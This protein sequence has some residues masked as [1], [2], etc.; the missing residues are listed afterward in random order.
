VLFNVHCLYPT[1]CFREYP[2]NPLQRTSAITDILP[3]RHSLF[4]YNEGIIFPSTPLPSK[5]FLFFSSFQLTFSLCVYLRNDMLRTAQAAQISTAHTYQAYYWLFH[6]LTTYNLYFYG[7]KM[8]IW[9]S[10]C[11]PF[12][13]CKK[14]LYKQEFVAHC[15][16]AHLSVLYT[17]S[18]RSCWFLSS[19]HFL[20]TKAGQKGDR[21]KN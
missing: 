8:R 7:R 9:R 4:R 11:Q 17:N 20:Q 5:Q 2:F 19:V 15:T 10:S 1:V 6:N 13:R 16:H 12:R 21:N 14:S 3:P 18:G